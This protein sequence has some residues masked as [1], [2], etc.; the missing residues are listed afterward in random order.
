MKTLAMKTGKSKIN[1]KLK[2]E[3]R[4]ATR[5]RPRIIYGDHKITEI[6]NDIDEIQIALTLYT[7]NMRKYDRYYTTS[8]TN[9]NN[10]SNN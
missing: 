6:N 2:R 8:N 5:S 7:E 3:S 10:E 9:N 1:V 4:K